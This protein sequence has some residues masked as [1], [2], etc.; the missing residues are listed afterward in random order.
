MASVDASSGYFVAGSSWLHARNPVTKLLGLLWVLVAAFIL[1]PWVL[2]PLGLGLVGLAVGSGFLGRAIGALRI[3]G[4]LIVSI[5]VVNL[6]FF[7]GAT[8]VLV[9][10]GPLAITGEG[11]EFGVVSASR[12]LVAFLASILFLTTTLADDLL[13]ALVSRGANHR[14]A[15]VIL[16]AMQTV[17]R[18]QARAADILE[19]QQARGLEV[20]G[21]LRLRIRALVPLVGPVLLGSLIDVRE[22][23]LALEARGFGARHE[24]TAY[25]VVADPPLDRWLRRLLLLG[26]VGIVAVRL[27]E[28]AGRLP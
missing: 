7:P 18:L 5:L 22:R 14:I 19:A 21:S 15:Y 9:A 28:A 3:P 24:R 6:L 1:P 10:I 8:H 12:L 11:L 13:E 20:T 4:V 17:P 16:S 25:R 27:L 26:F 2:V 23:T